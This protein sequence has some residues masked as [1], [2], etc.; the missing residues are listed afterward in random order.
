MNIDDIKQRYEP[1]DAKVLARNNSALRAEIEAHTQDF[2]KKKGKIQE[3]DPCASSPLVDFKTH[4]SQQAN[5]GQLN[6]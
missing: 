3:L 5:A 4:L 2:L 6:K 1:R